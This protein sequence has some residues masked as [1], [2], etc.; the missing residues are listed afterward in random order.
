MVL[1]VETGHKKGSYHKVDG[2][3]ESRYKKYL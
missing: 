1:Q 2:G 3:A